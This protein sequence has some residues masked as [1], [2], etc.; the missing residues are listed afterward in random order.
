MVELNSAVL[1]EQLH[2]LGLW[3]PPDLTE[4]V[5]WLEVAMVEDN[6]LARRQRNALLAT[7]TPREKEAA[8]ARAESIMNSIKAIAGIPPSNRNG[9]NHNNTLA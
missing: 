4:T 7:L 5:A 9:T 6:A 8:I 1:V 3:M 2:R